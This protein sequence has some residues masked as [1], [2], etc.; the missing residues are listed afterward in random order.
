MANGVSSLTDFAPGLTGEVNVFVSQLTL[1]LT[2]AGSTEMLRRQPYALAAH[3]P[4][5][6]ELQFPSVRDRVNI[7][8]TFDNL[9]VL[10]EDH[11]SKSFGRDNLINNSM[12]T[13][14]TGDGT[15]GEQR[16]QVIL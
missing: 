14:L 12:A 2:C 16:R 5:V 1:H 6:D 9:R 13:V 15:A 3:L 4:N 8:S 11:Q 10:Q 7:S